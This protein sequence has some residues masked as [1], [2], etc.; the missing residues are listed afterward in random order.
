MGHD[1]ET[2]S[3]PVHFPV[4]ADEPYARTDNWHG[5]AAGEYTSFL[6]PHL[7]VALTLEYDRLVAEAKKLLAE[8]PVPARGDKA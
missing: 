7:P 8:L 6:G 3:V 4:R 5:S 2:G 1:F